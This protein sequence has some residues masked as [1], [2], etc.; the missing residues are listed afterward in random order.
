MVDRVYREDIPALRRA[1]EK[2]RDDLAGI[3]TRT[4]WTKLRIEPL[5]HHAHALE[6]RLGSREFSREATRLRRG[7]EMF[8]ADLVY[9]REN[10][11]G[12]KRVLLAERRSPPT[13]RRDRSR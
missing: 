7:V 3:E 10:V 12:L 8:H 1:L 5:L 4:D 9:L 6:R 11:R 2:L 13:K